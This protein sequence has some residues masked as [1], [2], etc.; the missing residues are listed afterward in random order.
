MMNL[1][2]KIN[3]ETLN[4]CKDISYLLFTCFKVSRH[5]KNVSKNVKKLMLALVLILHQPKSE[6]DSDA[7]YLAIMKSSQ[8]PQLHFWQVIVTKWL[9]DKLF[10]GQK[11]Q[12]L[13]RSLLRPRP[14]PKRPKRPRN[15][16]HQKEQVK[17]TLVFFTV[18]KQV[19]EF[20]SGGKRKISTRITSYSA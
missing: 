13:R 2:N 20:S 12:F 5:L 11:L 3:F 15:L 4:L 6:T 14:R 7:T 1:K 8:L 16:H 17:L 9:E 18:A 10:L 19:M